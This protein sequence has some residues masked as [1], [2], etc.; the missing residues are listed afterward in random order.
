[1]KFAGILREHE[2]GLIKVGKSLT[3]LIVSA[4][5]EIEDLAQI[6]A[7]LK[8]G[9][10]VMGFLHYVYDSNNNPIAPMVYYSD[11]KWVW[12]SYLSYYLSLNYFSLI[13][14]EFI[15]DIRANHYIPPKLKEDDVENAQRLYL[16]T[17]ER[18]GSHT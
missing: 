4:N 15:A 14:D 10:Y 13:P 1:M 11:G 7:Y 2:G 12:P 18:K 3:E 17:Y 8:K 6:I 5:E 9:T 16:A